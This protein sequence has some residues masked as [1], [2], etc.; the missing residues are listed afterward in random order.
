MMKIYI[1]LLGFVAFVGISCANNRPAEAK[2]PAEVTGDTI[3]TFTFPLIPPVLQTPESRA[4]YLIEH[5]WEN[6]NWA[7]TNYVHHPEIIEQAWVNYL[8]LLPMVSTEKASAVLKALFKSAEANKVCVDYLAKLADKYLYDPNSPMRN[9]EY[10][11]PVLDAL[12]ASPL[13]GDAEKIR[14]QALRKLA[15]Q[16]RVGTQALDFEYTLNSGKRG[17]LHAL[18]ATYLLLY[19]NNPGCHT[20]AVTTDE[21]KS[22]AVISQAVASGN[23]VILSLYPDEEL[24]EWKRHQS[25]FPATWINAYDARQ[26]IKEQ[27][28]YDLKAIPTLYLLDEHKTVL[29]KDATASQVIDYLLQVD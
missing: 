15:Q 2:N 3:T 16:N 24:A 10:Y 23:L 9:E 21:L 7:D 25:D 11:I 22:S 14:P 4:E 17:S 12:I 28:L 18:R 27:G 8:D 5:Y 13:L 20:C 6:V 1:L 19:I 29:L 26:H